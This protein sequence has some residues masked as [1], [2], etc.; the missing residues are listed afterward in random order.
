M[1]EKIYAYLLRLFP[2][3]FRKHYEEEAL[4]LL[5]DRLSNERGFFRRLRLGFDLI[6]DMIGALP[7]AYRNSYAEVAAAASLTPQFDGVPSF[8][9]L[10]KEPIRRRVIVIACILTIAALATLSYVMEQPISYHSPERNDPRFYIDSVLERLNQPPSPDSANKVGSGRGYGPGYGDNT[11]RG[12]YHI[13]GSVSTPVPLFIVDAEFSD[14]ARRAKLQGVCL[15]SLTVDAQ[16]NP[17]NP[18]VVRALGM[19]LDEKALEAVRKYRFK[20]AMKDG[21]IPVPVRVTVVVNFRLY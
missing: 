14:E 7:V 11:G 19:G 3:A 12:L 9:T 10:Q 1:S 21:R 20:P 4:R 15:I 16:G 8:R 2:S 6:M 18:Q 5:R 13:G 17:Q